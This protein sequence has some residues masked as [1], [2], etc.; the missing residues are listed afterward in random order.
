[1]EAILTSTVV[2]A[3]AE[4]GDKTQLLAIVL[5]A[6]VRKPIPIIL[7]IL[8]ATLLN[9]AVAAALGYLV[10]QWVTGR[11]FQ[12]VLGVAF[13]AMAAWALV[14]D[15]E[16]EG[17]D[18]RSAGGIFLTTLVAF[19][20][21]EIGDKTQIATSLLAAQFDDI[22]MVT[23]GTTAGMMLANVPAVLLGDVVTKTIPLKYVRVTAALIFAAIGL[24]VVV[25][26]FLGDDALS[27]RR[28]TTHVKGQTNSVMAASVAPGVNSLQRS[29]FPLS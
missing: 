25:A 4:I 9:H 15:K 12:A 11:T 18:E 29:S 22:T 24:W 26:A 19:F 27:A 3:I 6:R 14:P 5:A 17:A 7:G 10:A 1:M 21:V 28:M 8:A 13:I 16:Q 20:L 2:V 23:I